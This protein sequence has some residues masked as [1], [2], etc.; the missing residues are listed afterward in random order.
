MLIKL[1]FVIFVNTLFL[2]SSSV[3]A[4][5]NNRIVGNNEH[6]ITKRIDNFFT[7]HPYEKR[8]VWQPVLRGKS[9]YEFSMI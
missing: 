6:N 1:A 4:E 3:R 9:R 2:L 8:V 5:I 7:M